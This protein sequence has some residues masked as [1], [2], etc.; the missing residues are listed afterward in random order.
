V[1][2]CH[3]LSPLGLAEIA[4]R[5][6]GPSLAQMLGEP[7]GVADA[8]ARRAIAEARAGAIGAIAVRCGTRV[9]T[10]LDDASVGGIAALERAAGRVIRVESEAGWPDDRF[11][12]SVIGR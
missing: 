7:S 8:I 2:A 11:E 4:R 9:A 12:V 10:V 5:R 3:G 6:A 1:T